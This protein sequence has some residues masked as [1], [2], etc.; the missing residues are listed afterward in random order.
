MDRL[1][2]WV[3]KIREIY[4]LNKFSQQNRQYERSSSKGERDQGD[5]V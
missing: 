2:V 4:F 5:K 1:I 3:V